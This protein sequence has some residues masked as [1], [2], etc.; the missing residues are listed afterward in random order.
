MFCMA[1]TALL[2]TSK[3]CLF[4]ILNEEKKNGD[5]HFAA[6]HW[7]VRSDTRPIFD[8]LSTLRQ[9]FPFLQEGHRKDANTA[10]RT[11][12]RILNP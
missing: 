9:T 6:V 8:S 4:L 10:A 3:A 7:K 11:E 1:K 5:K 12:I 2:F